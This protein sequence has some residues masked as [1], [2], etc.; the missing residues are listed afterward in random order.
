MNI[1]VA[2]AAVAAVFAAILA[3]GPGATPPALAAPAN[4]TSAN[5]I[6]FDVPADSGLAA[7]INTINLHDMAA[8]VILAP[9]ML[10]GARAI[11]GPACPMPSQ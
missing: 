1:R 4:D 2:I 9:T 11:N 3:R 7:F 10:N 6:P 5:A 8:I